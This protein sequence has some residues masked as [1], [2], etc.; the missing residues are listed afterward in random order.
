M[1]DKYNSATLEEEKVRVLQALTQFKDTSLLHETLERSLTEEVR[2]HDAV[3]VVAGVG[4]SPEGRGV[5][6]AYLKE[7]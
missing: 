3:S 1:W 4:S 5:A 6:W 2:V 7:N